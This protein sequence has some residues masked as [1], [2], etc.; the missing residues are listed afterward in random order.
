[1]PQ[2]RSAVNGREGKSRHYCGLPR[3]LLIMLYDGLIVIA[4]MMFAT[5]LLL[6][7]TS[8]SVV[9]GK[10]P[11]FTA[12]LA[13]IWFLY[14]AWCWRHGGMTVGMRAWKVK[15]ASDQGSAPSWKQC[16]I[17]FATSLLS[18]A[19]LGAGFISALFEDERRTWHDRLSQTRLVR[20]RIS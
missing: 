5:A 19:L 8:G 17:R 7:V 12:C 9:A 13:A 6:P 1:M 18:A 15:L 4:L 10:D 14:L 20:T 16:F 11:A 2:D 3:R